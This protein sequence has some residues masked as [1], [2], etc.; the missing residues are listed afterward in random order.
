MSIQ[1]NLPIN[2]F[3]TSGFAVTRLGLGMAALGR[4][5]YIN[6]GH[7]D[8]LNRRYDPALMEAHAHRVCT[9]A[10]EAGIRYFD[11]ARSY[12]QGEAFLGSWLRANALQPEAVVVGSKWG[13]TY[14]AA[15]RTDAAVH[16]V[17]EH[18]LT[19][20][21][22]QWA[23]SQVELGP[24]LRLYQIHSATLESGVLTRPEVL[25]ALAEK[26]AAGLLIGLSVSGPQ[27]GEVI[28]RALEVRVDGVP[29]FGAVQATWNLLEPSAGSAL[30]EAAAAGWG[31]IIKEALA[32]GR[33]TARNRDPQFAT[34]RTLLEAE[35]ARLNCTLDALALAACLAQPWLSVVLSGATTVAQVQANVAAAHVA[36]DAQAATRLA[37]LGETPAAYWA[38]RAALPWN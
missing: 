14:T 27:Q 19:V 11:T 3:G 29:L 30:H 36:W 38:T 1:S 21:E 8:D 17:K 23:E 32:N 5:G 26:R 10:W 18:S 15:W 9:A 22:R 16:E 2:P 35:A 31:V 34:T 28:R 37:A 20:L 4:P 6:L 25:R 7:A 13:Y 12:G 24:W 33:L